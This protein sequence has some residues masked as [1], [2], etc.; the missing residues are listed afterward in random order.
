[1]R[2]EQRDM[3]RSVVLSVLF[4][5]VRVASVQAEEERNMEFAIAAS[6]IDQYKTWGKLPNDLASVRTRGACSCAARLAN[7]GWCNSRVRWR[8]LGSSGKW[9]GM[10]RLN[11]DGTILLH[12][13][14]QIDPLCR[15]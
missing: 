2:R 11:R 14:R 9:V 4:E 6:N 15:A 7:M 13:L 10:A 3:K 1:M 8:M 12:H 5:Q